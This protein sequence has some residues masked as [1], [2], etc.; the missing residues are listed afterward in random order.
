MRLN[1]VIRENFMNHQVYGTRYRDTIILQH[2]HIRILINTHTNDV[3]PHCVPTAC[4]SDYDGTA[5]VHNPEYKN[6]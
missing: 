3:T 6:Q 2:I 5:Q 4:S 1:Y